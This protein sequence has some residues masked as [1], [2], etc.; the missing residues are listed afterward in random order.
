MSTDLKVGRL[1]LRA[2]GDLWR[3]FYAMP[4]TLDNALFLGSIKLGLVSNNEN[5][6]M[7]FMKLM[8]DAVADILEKVSGER[9]TYPDG[10]QPAPEHERDITHVDESI[11]KQLE[12]SMARNFRLITV[13]K[14]VRKQM[15]GDAPEAEMPIWEDVLKKVNDAIAN[16]DEK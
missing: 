1:A 3:A 5:Q 10:P 9:P 15:T 11:A 6:K 12:R 2:D 13:L 14:E 7:A 8:Q 4:D 16:N